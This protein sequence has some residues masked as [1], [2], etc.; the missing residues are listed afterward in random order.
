MKLR[1]F[2][3]IFTSCKVEQPLGGVGLQEKKEEKDDKHK[4]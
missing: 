2:L 1:F 3:I 4:G